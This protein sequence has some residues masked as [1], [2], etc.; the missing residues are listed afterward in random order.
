MILLIMML[1]VLID[2]DDK[3]LGQ[4]V[5]AGHTHAVQTAAYLV[6]AAAELT[7]RVQ[8][9]KTQFHRRYAFLFVNAAGNT[10]SVVFDGKRTVFVY[11]NIYV[12][13]VTCQRF[14]DRVIYNLD[15]QVM[16]PLDVSRADVH[17]R[18]FANRFQSFQ[19]L[20]L[21]F[22]ISDVFRH[23]LLLFSYILLP[24]AQHQCVLHNRIRRPSSIR[25]KRAVFLTERRK[26]L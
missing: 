24:T 6:S 1:A 26:S 11:G 14:V 9:G 15:G 10:A 18:S 19:N 22:G 23:N 4:R 13:A 17:T 12:I 25:C 20:Y 21:L 3:P 2:F 5:N 8:L 7:A 16:Q